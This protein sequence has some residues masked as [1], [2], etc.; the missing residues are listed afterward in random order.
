ML[1]CNTRSILKGIFVY[2]E[3][4]PLA[5]IAIDLDGVIYGTA[6]VKVIP[7]QR[8]CQHNHCPGSVKNIKG[9]GPRLD[10]ARAEPAL[11]K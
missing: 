6:E 8:I 2:F 11:R 7:N 9:T 1:L 3:D 5:E 4:N 10:E